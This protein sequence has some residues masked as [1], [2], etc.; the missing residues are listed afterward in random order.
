M[1]INARRLLPNS[2]AYRYNSISALFATSLVWTAHYI[3]FNLELSNNTDYS[4]GQA[5]K[6][7]L[8]F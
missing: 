6:M 7:Y 3:I 1:R 4:N 8:E 2:G 5:V